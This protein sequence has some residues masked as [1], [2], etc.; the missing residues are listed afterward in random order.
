MSACGGQLDQPALSELGDPL[1]AT[2]PATGAVAT[3]FRKDPAAVLDYEVDWTAWLTEAGDTIDTSTWTVPDGITV[4]SDTHTATV[5]T[6]W[7]SGGTLGTAY[8]VTNRIT[9]AGGRTDE[10]TIVILVRDR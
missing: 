7:L 3:S 5:A 9:T 6:I 2:F 10:R 8:A 1:P 4:D